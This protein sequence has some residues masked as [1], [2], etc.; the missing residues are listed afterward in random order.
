MEQNKKS[1]EKENSTRYM[2]A[3]DLL[4]V[5]HLNKTRQQNT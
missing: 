1:N 2:Q 3:I 4:Y 5:F